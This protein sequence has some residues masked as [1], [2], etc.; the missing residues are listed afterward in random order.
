MST[1]SAL[2]FIAVLKQFLL[3]LA[4]CCLGALG[5]IEGRLG[6][7]DYQSLNFGI[8]FFVALWLL[9]TFIAVI[10]ESKKLT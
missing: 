10:L 3:F 1:K 4:G 9:S 2:S 8:Y 6:I 7:G 5:V